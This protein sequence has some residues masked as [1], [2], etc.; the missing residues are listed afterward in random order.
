MFYRKVGA[1]NHCMVQNPKRIPSYEV[2]SDDVSSRLNIQE[3]AQAP[4]GC[5]KYC[6][7]SDPKLPV[8][9]RHSF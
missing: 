5:V 7:I 3:I 8:K 1:F 2:L 6:E 9:E 4:P